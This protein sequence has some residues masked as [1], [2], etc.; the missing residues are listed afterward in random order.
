MQAR[1]F[2]RFGM[3]HTSMAWRPDFAANLADGYGLDGSMEPHDERSG[4]SA[5]GSI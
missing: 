3:T 1:V 2:D 4:A 5:A